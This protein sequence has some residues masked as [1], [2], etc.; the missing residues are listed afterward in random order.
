VGKYFL[1]YPKSSIISILDISNDQGGK[2]RIN[3]SGA[4]DD[5][6]QAGTPITQYGLILALGI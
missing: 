6:V 4:R 1:K 3:W 2:V 5:V